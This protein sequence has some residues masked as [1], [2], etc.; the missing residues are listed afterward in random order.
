MTTSRSSFVSTITRGRGRA[1]AAPL[2]F[3]LSSVAFALFT[4]LCA[5]IR[6]YVPFTPVPI[7]GQ[8]FAVLLSGVVLGGWFGALSQVFYVTF[9]LLGV[10]WFVLGPLGPTWGYIVGFI[11]AP[12]AVS[13]LR[14]R[15][16]K[17]R[18]V[19]DALALLGGVSVIYCLGT[20]HFSLYTGM[21]AVESIRYTVIPFIPFDAGKA[22]AVFAI[23][24][25][26]G[27]KVPRGTPRTE[28]G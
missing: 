28:T 5:R 14:E 17:R 19:T 4:G 20:V 13:V 16:A 23:A 8:V 7:T 24:R 10:D 11:L 27:E 6:V 15:D 25:L 12:V 9:G 21:S 18:G 22:L 2:V 3:F 1:S 26:A